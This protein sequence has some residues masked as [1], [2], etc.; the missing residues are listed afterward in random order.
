M[1][2]LYLLPLLLSLS[3]SLWPVNF[4]SRNA[5]ASQFSNDNDS[6]VTDKTKVTSPCTFTYKAGPPTNSESFFTGN[7]L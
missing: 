4:S 7:Q 6:E 2:L 5:G 1:G 3:L